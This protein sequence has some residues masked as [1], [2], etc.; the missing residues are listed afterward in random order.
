VLGDGDGR[1]A[2]HVRDGDAAPRARREID[3]V[4]AGRG[5]GDQL[6]AGQSR[7]LRLA[8]RDLVHDRNRRAPQP[9]DRLLLLRLRVL[10][11]LVREGGPA[12][13]RPHRVAFEKGD[14]LHV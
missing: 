2:A 3:P 6:E 1:V 10:A 9:L 11:P 8:E 12:D 7:Q 5:D 14:L 4:G 13:L